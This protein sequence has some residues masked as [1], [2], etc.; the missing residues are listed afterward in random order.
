M[1]P[2]SEKPLI[3]ARAI[4]EIDGLAAIGKFSDL[5]KG[6]ATFFEQKGDLANANIIFQKGTLTEFKSS[7]ELQSVVTAWTEMH[8]RNGNMDSAL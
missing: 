1:V 2:E 6:F 4:T 3:F 7:D 8:L 5:W